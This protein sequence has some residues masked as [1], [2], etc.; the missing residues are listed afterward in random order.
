MNQQAN[1]DTFSWLTDNLVKPGSATEPDPA[2]KNRTD[3]WQDFAAGNIGMINGSPSLVPILAKGAIGSNY[4]V[5]PIAGKTGPLTSPLGVADFIVAFN[6]HPDH[7]AA[8][9]KFLDFALAKKYQEQFDNLYYLLPATQ[10]AAS[11]LSAS[12]AT[13]KPFID[14][15]PGAT[16]YPFTDPKWTDVP[17]R[18]RTLWVPR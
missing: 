3:L 5:A 16:W 12:N 8:I 18:S 1:V 10:S 17:R 2:T 14:G 13:L 9:Q 11:D 15:L 4:A 7:K 6:T